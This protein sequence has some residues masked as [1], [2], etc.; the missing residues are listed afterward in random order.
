MQMCQQ[1]INRQGDLFMLMTQENIMQHIMWN[2][3]IILLCMC[4]PREFLKELPVF[5]FFCFSLS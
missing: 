3:F 2:L 1:Y 4:F 5:V